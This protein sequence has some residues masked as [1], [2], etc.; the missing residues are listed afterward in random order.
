MA[1]GQ[2]AY[3][4]V[5]MMNGRAN[6]LTEMVPVERIMSE[7][8]RY[9]K[10]GATHYILLNTSEIRPVP[11]TIKAVMDISWRGLPPSPDSSDRFYHDWAA[12]QFGEK[13]ADKIAQ[14]YKDYFTAPAHVAD[15][16]HLDG[17]AQLN[18]PASQEVSPPCVQIGER[19]AI[20][21]TLRSPA[22][23]RHRH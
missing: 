20:A 10:A 6:Q 18:C 7:L 5:A 23:L 17:K 2:G 21:A 8:G 13:A 15:P 14:V 4:H 1:T 12:E 3:Y 19:L 9:I 16:I 11:M 22:N